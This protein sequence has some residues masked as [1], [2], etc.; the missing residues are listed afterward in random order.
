MQLQ[1]QQQ[2]QQGRCG[3]EK[4]DDVTGSN[5]EELQLK[6]GSAMETIADA[7]IREGMDGDPEVLG[8]TIDNLDLLLEA[9]H[10]TTKDM[11]TNTLYYLNHPDNADK[12]QR[13]RE[14]AKAFV[15]GDTG[16]ADEE[17]FPT[18][19]QL[20]NEMPYAEASIKEA[21][22]LAPIISGVTYAVKDDVS[23]TFK[24]Q[25]MQGPSSFM[26]S[27]GQNF[28]DPKFFPRPNEYMPERWDPDSDMYVS[29][30]AQAAYRPFGAGRHMCLGYQLA[31]LVM[32][33]TLYCFAREETRTIE[34]DTNKVGTKFG[35]FPSYS[36]SDGFPAKVTSGKK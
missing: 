13:L 18:F 3:E 20:K 15:V 35:L 6:I 33:S 8:E 29:K 16:T 10:G 32:K 25:L 2:Q 5:Q 19:A 7:L 9:S 11:T 36:I 26:L 17:V 27:W 30:E 21:M 12:L 28:V 14:E 1:Q 23:F 34:F 24:G 4:K 31:L 22:R